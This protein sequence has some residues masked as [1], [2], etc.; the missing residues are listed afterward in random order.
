[1][2]MMMIMSDVHDV[3]NRGYYDDDDDDGSDDF[4]HTVIAMSSDNSGDGK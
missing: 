3:D 4:K 1:M 2:M